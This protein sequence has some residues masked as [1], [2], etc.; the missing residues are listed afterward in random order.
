MAKRDSGKTTETTE[1]AAA[2]SDA[3]EQRVVAFAE[4]IGR[5][6][7]T[8]SARA[9]GMVDREALKKQI[10]GVRDSA[11]ELLEHLS[12]GVTSIAS[13][14]KKTAV[15]ATATAKK[16]GRGLV[17]APGKKHRKP[18]PKDPRAIAADAKRSTLQAG[19]ASMKTTKTRGRG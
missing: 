5:I 14:A 3:V 15:K 12:D 10:A 19:K 6:A 9:E 18:M 1:A 4:Q 8:V 16:Q 13:R 11:A 7:G 2:M 17:D